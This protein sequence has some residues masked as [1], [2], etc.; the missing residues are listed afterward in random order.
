MDIL[1]KEENGI[2]TFKV[3]SLRIDASVVGELKDVVV[4]DIVEGAKIILDLN[5]VEYMDSTS[6]SVLVFFYKEAKQKGAIFKI[7]TNNDKVLSIFITTG[8]IRALEI[9]KDYDE[10]VKEILEGS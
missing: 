5:N 7:V 4:K 6:L 9:V 3:N 8:L 2:I 10:A 1:R